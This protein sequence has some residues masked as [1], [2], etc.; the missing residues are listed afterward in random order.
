MNQ[1]I[2]LFVDAGYLFK[3]GA[4]VRF[5]T[6]VP[7]LGLRFDPALFVSALLTGVAARYP[8]ESVRRTYWYDGAFHG[9]ASPNHHRVAELDYVK[10][11][12]GRINESG[13]QKG[14]DTLLV[15]DLMV[16]SQERSIERA[17]VLTGD[18][19]VRE[20]I[21]YAQD[22]GVL[23]SVMGIS[24]G[25]RNSPTKQSQELCR[26]ADELVVLDPGCLDALALASR[27]DS[28][29]S[30]RLS[31]QRAT[32]SRLSSPRSPPGGRT[33]WCR[34]ESASTAFHRCGFRWRSIASS[35][36]RS[37]DDSAEPWPRTRASAVTS[38]AGSALRSTTSSS[39]PLRACRAGWA[40]RAGS[41]PD[42]SQADQPV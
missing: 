4:L 33:P 24:D 9:V 34:A 15:R 42:H 30:R 31:R 40:V 35:C 36:L 29:S 41:A 11:R 37:L 5:G 25:T 7:R 8:G 6:D 27:S 19:D 32:R 10:L 13:Q 39:E 3:Q 17:V 28:D 16:L 1:R 22:R 12:L 21:E 23:V 20:G 14:V 38:G 18:E 26:A 2:A